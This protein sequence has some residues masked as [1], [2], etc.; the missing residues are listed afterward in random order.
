MSILAKPTA[1]GQAQSHDRYFRGHQS[2]EQRLDSALE[3]K[4]VARQRPPIA[5]ARSAS[6]S[7]PLATS[8]A[9]LPSLCL[10]AR[11][12]RSPQIASADQN[13]AGEYGPSPVMPPAHKSLIPTLNVAKA[14]GWPTG[15]MPRAAKGAVV[16]SFAT[17]LRHPRW[18]YVLPNGDVLVAETEAP[19][20]PR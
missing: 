14:V 12:G 1:R 8:P 11:C 2:G 10:S 15:M 17:G 9:I 19:S 4:G 5:L 7:T 13:A 20:Q 18:L 6:G 3:R 16:D